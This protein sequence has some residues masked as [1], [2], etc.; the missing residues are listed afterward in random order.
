MRDFAV[1]WGQYGAWEHCTEKILLVPWSDK[2]NYS[3]QKFQK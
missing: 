2:L 1:V 3:E